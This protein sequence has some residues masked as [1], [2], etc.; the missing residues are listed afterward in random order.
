MQKLAGKDLLVQI[1]VGGVWYS[2]P[3]ERTSTGSV[4]NEQVDTTTKSDITPSAFKRLAQYGVR[5]SELKSAGVSAD[6]VGRIPFNFL[7]ARVFDGAFFQARLLSSM[8]VVFTD[9]FQISSLERSGEYNKADMYDVK[10]VRA[11]AAA[12]VISSFSVYSVPTTV[13]SASVTIYGA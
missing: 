11:N 6:E 8:V 5:S 7:Q 1:L 9:M 10:M 2:V 3:G 13:Y 12:V 4:T